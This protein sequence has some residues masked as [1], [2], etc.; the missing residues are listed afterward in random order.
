VT[1]NLKDLPFGIAMEIDDRIDL[2]TKV[3]DAC[4]SFDEDMKG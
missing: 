3:K 2:M 4:S 1:R